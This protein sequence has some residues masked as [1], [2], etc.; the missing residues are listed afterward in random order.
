MPN[1]NP[2]AK[3]GTRLALQSWRLFTLKDDNETPVDL[4][5][6]AAFYK[7]TA[8]E[9]ARKRAKEQGLSLRACYAINTTK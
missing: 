2:N 3:A 5:G 1:D 6:F 8:L 9:W 7:E 4:G